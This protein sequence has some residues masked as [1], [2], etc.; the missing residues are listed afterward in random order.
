M[1]TKKAV[2][3]ALRLT[4]GAAKTLNKTILRTIDTARSEM[5]RAGVAESIAKSDIPL[6]QD[7]VVTFCLYKMD[8]EAQREANWSAFEYQL[9]C[10]RKSSNVGAP[11]EEEI[12][13][14]TVKEL[15]E[16]IAALQEQINALAQIKSVGTGLDLA[17]ETGEL[18]NTAQG[19]KGDKGDPFTYEDFTAEQLAALKGEKGD[20]GDPGEQGPQGEKGDKGDDG[21]SPT[22][23]SYIVDKPEGSSPVSGNVVQVGSFTN[24]DGAEYGIFEFYYRTSALP[25]ADAMKEYL[26]TPLLDNYTI[27]DFIDGTGVTSNGFII[28]NGRTDG[29]NRV[30]IQQFSK[31]RKAVSL[32]SYGDLTAQT[33]LLKIK[34][35]GTKNA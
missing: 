26:C 13:M 3:E 34:F 6:V 9:D 23:P 10:L 30:I 19:E 33:A 24:T 17:E 4:D 32:R 1:Q 8:D 18:T 15:R 5:I 20:K 31:N 2:I 16:Q 11:A 25:N 7:A 28:S 29:T 35:I 21:Y 22:P 12:D 14:E 27:F